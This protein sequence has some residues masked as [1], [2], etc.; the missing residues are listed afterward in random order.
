MFRKVDE[1]DIAAFAVGGGV[2]VEGG[3]GGPEVRAALPP[4]FAAVRAPPQAPLHCRPLLLCAPGPADT[5]P[6]PPAPHQ[7][8]YRG[9]EEER[10]D[11]LRHYREC[12]GAMDRV[13]EWVMLSRP[14]VDAHRF[15]GALDAAIAAG[16][17]GGAGAGAS[18][19]GACTRTAGAGELDAQAGSQPQC[20]GVVITGLLVAHCQAHTKPPIA[21]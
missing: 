4:K 17:G 8:K 6:H 18:S 7:A 1:D 9:S 3:W 19:A 10:A 15:M 12:G 2:G 20:L 13:F 14:D 11:L 16:A 5:R 21:R